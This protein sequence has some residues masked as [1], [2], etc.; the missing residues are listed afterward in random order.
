MAARAKKLHRQHLDASQRARLAAKL[1][2]IN[3]ITQAQAAKAMNVSQK[4]VSDAVVVDSEATEE[5]KDAVVNGDM[6]LEDA[7]NATCGI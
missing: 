1:V 4:S 2:A 7:A 3:G 5:A 6:S